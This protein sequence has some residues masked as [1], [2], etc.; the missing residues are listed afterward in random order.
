M[1]IY[2]VTVNIE[3]NVHDEWLKFMKDE[4]IPDVMKNKL[5]E[6]ENVKCL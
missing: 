4:H 3:H 2:N 6:T 1:I 5:S